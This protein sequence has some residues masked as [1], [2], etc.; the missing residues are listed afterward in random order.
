MRRGA[1][2][3]RLPPPRRPRTP[4]SHSPS[5]ELDTTA[6]ERVTRQQQ[7]LLEASNDLPLP[8]PTFQPADS[9]AASAGEAASP[10]AGGQPTEDGAASAPP[11]AEVVEK[12]A[13]AAAA[14]VAA[15][16]A[17]SAPPAPVAAPVL[18][19]KRAGIAAPVAAGGGVVAAPATAPAVAAARPPLA[20]KQA[21]AA[22]SKPKAKAATTS[23]QPARGKS[24]YMLFCDSR[25]AALVAATPGLAFGD[26]TK[27]LAAEWKVLD[28]AAKA[29]FEEMAVADKARAA[30]ANAAGGLVAAPAG[31]RAPTAYQRF[32]AEV[33]PTLAAANPG[34]D[35]GTMSKLLGEAWK[36]ADAA[37]R[38]Q[39]EASA[40]AAAAVAGALGGGG[41]RKKGA[42]KR[43][44]DPDGDDEIVPQSKRAAA[45]AAA[46]AVDDDDD[47]ADRLS[48]DWTAH[49]PAAILGETAAGHFIVARTG[50]PFSEYGLVDAAA[51]KRAAAGVAPA[52]APPCPLPAALVADYT[53][54]TAAFNAALADRSDSAG[55]LDLA[56]L[57]DGDALDACALLW[58][59]RTRGGPLDAA[60]AA[61]GGRGAASKDPLI[62]VLALAL[63]RLVA[64]LVGVAAVAG[65]QGAAGGGAGVGEGEA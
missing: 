27:A 4:P 19:K 1:A 31:K 26:V 56:D 2:R 43:K 5:F 34:A 24:S 38:A 20:A 60:T 7:H 18:G 35:M 3:A 44:C 23:T 25:R 55:G 15:P 48:V 12:A 33:R 29:P 13:E 47:T 9:L 54:S 49:P 65:G 8:P 42:G 57:Q 37:V 6:L 51:A 39:Y 32:C 52:D 53:A 40:A 41:A 36:G 61:A 63:S 50:L 58:R 30:A 59:L 14:P 22:L 21:V 45:A 28:A 11:A 10:A 62:R 46:A 64:R 16:A 17:P